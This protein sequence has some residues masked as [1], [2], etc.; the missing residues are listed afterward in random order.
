[1]VT[2]FCPFLPLFRQVLCD[3]CVFLTFPSFTHHIKQHT[4]RADTHN[5]FNGKIAIM[6][7]MSRKIVGAKLIF[8][9]KTEF[10]K[11]ISPFLQ[12]I[13]MFN[14][15]ISAFDLFANRR[16]AQNHIS[17]FLNRHLCAVHKTACRISVNLTVKQRILSGIVRCKFKPPSLA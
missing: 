15:I 14:C 3:F 7:K 6:R 9:V 17:A 16:N 2:V 13:K 8:G 5:C 11:I 10:H 12:N 4:P 1:M